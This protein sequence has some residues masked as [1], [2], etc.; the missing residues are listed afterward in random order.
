MLNRWWRKNE[1]DHVLD[2]VIADMMSEEE[3]ELTLAQ[4]AATNAECV[5]LF[6]ERVRSEFAVTPRKKKQQYAEDFV[7]DQPEEG[8]VG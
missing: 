5:Q 2:V 7:I 6:H 3:W 1:V 8:R 4:P